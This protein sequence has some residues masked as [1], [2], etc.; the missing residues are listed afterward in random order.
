M[1][2][3]ASWSL[4]EYLRARV[5]LIRT[6]DGFHTDL[7]AGAIVLDDDELPDDATTPM[8]A[9]EAASADPEI[10]GRRFAKSTVEV[11]V[12][13]SVPRGAGAENPKL[14]VHRARTDLIRALLVDPKTLPRGIASLEITGATLG[15]TS[16]QV[17]GV[18]YA[19]AQV[20]VRAGL[21][22]T[23]SSANS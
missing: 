10:T 11:T 14:L 19:I 16:D 9:I 1:A 6:E 15:S 17:A 8:T 4:L 7:G 20:S 18:S 2:E 22:E 12:E 3:P 13:F 23:D 5:Q 21:I